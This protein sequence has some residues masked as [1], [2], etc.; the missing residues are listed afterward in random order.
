MLIDQR[1]NGLFNIRG[2]PWMN[3]GRWNFL[4]FIILLL[5]MI[6]RGS[7][8]DNSIDTFFDLLFLLIRMVYFVWLVKCIFGTRSVLLIIWGMRLI[9]SDPRLCRVTHDQRMFAALHFLSFFY[10]ESWRFLINHFLYLIFKGVKVLSWLILI[11]HIRSSSL[12]D[13]LNLLILWGL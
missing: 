8:I 6:V 4:V 3:I 2:F 12:S 5:I 11:S 9:I 7:P 10:D 13:S 1:I